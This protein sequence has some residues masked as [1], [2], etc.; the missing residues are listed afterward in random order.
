[1]KTKFGTRILNL[2]LI[3]ILDGTFFSGRIIYAGLEGFYRS[4]Y[5]F[6]YGG[7]IRNE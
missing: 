2:S 7:L 1:M 6:E 5:F 3:M 4:I